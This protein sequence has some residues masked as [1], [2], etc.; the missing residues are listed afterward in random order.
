M[1]THKNLFCLVLSALM[2]TG[3][4]SFPRILFSETPQEI[5]IESGL[6]PG[7]RV[8]PVKKPEKD[9]N[10]YQDTK[11]DEDK[12]K[13]DSKLEVGGVLMWDYD[14]FNGVHIG[15]AQDYQVGNETELRRARIDLKSEMDR[16]WEAELQVSFEY[17]DSS[18]EVDD[19]YIAFTGWDDVTL[20]FGKTKEPFGLEELTG[21]SNITLIERSMATSAFA[22][23]RHPG[24]SLSDEKKAFTWAVGI[25]E[26]ADRENRRD[27]YA[28]TGHLTLAL[29]EKKKRVLHLG[30]SGSVRDF[31]GAIYRIEEQA[32]VHTA[33]EI[34]RSI[35]TPADDVRLLGVECAWVMGPFSVQAEHMTAWIEAAAGEDADYSGY[36]IQGSYFLTGEYRPYKKGSFKGIKP[37][38][39]Y[40]AL[41]VVSRFSFLDAEDHSR[42]V[43][44]ENLTLGL[45]YY[46]NNRVR[47]MINY[48]KTT[49]TDGVSG[50]K[51]S[52]D[53][54]SSRMQYEF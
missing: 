39:R 28:L 26:A 14:Q 37:S 45:N 38:A 27:T 33:E 3:V 41:E 8:I 34:V 11:P 54:I 32:E 16:D 43:R 19:A 25:Y 5:I 52:A 9:K 17:E 2:L 18:I 29:W 53:A 36:Y 22:P 48:I 12:K 47:L 10:Q 13:G 44:A 1:D 7:R 46:P 30:I 31:D 35:E 20:T 42:G 4:I 50:V 21:S 49:L 23:G 15:R 40:G 51:G 24:L 6:L